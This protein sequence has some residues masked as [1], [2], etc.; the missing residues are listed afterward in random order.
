MVL[1]FQSLVKII[2]ALFT[3]ILCL[4]SEV[5]LEKMLSVAKTKGI[6][7]PEGGIRG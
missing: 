1:A 6:S 4:D 5:L 3:V 2:Q 7:V